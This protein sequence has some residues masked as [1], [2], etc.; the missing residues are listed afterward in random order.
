MHPPKANTM[1]RLLGIDVGTSSVKA[2]IFDVE[3]ARVLAAHGEEYPI[4]TPAADRA[5]QD[6]D[7]Y[8]RAT[9]R[10]V[11][12]VIAEVGD[13][14]V[15]AVGFSGQMH[16][17][18]LLDAQSRPLSRA[19]IWADARAAHEP[20]RLVEAFPAFADV[21]GTLPAAGFMVCTLA[22]LRLHQPELLAQA[23][24]V[25]LPKDYVRLKMTGTVATDVTDAA[26]TGMLDV[27]R[28][29]WADAILQAAGISRDLCPPI[30]QSL[31][32]VGP[33]LPQAAE[34]LGLQAGVPVTAGCADQPAQAIGNGLIAP[35]AASITI[36]TGGQIFVPLQPQG[37]LRTD[38]RL[39][40]FNHAAPGQWYVLGAILSA[41]MSLRWLRGILGLENDPQAYSLLAAEAEQVSP[42]ADG[43]LFLPYL[44][45]ERTPF[46]DPQAR[47]GFL[48]LRLH[49][50]RG[51]MARAVIEGVCFAVRQ[52]YE[53]SLTI[54]QPVDTIIASGGA[55]ESS[56]WR[57]IMTDILGQPMRKSLMAE[58]A[59]LG[60]ALLAGAGAGVY[61]SLS[62]ACAQVVRYGLPSTPDEVRHALYEDQYAQF[63]TLYPLLRDQMHMLA[64]RTDRKD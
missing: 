63:K 2:L 12:R 37:K 50:G 27:A 20:Q 41:G 31:A 61:A 1:T 39:H 48:G 52:A 8:W 58:Q 15:A 23:H 57:S 38:A 13:N 47:G 16:G 59:S 19:I 42:G 64:A 4:H 51:H 10:A 44:A 40:V 55:L 17:T 33:L 35:G 49:H 54:S 45:G 18:I 56:V 25:I 14:D 11:R 46:M 30:L 7:D 53:L 60:A 5:E 36:G 21:A 34:A 62:D 22:W 29:D 32:V 6:P 9:V 28:A 26:S 3:G 24:R 43:L